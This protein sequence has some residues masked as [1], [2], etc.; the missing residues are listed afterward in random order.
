MYFWLKKKGNKGRAQGTQANRSPLLYLSIIL[1][2][3]R[4]KVNY[5]FLAQYL[6]AK[7]ARFYI[8][9][10]RKIALFN[11][12]GHN[13]TSKNAIISGRCLCIMTDSMTDWPAAPAHAQHSTH[14]DAL[15]TPQKSKREKEGQRYGD[16]TTPQH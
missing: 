9:K 7:I 13:G 14:G 16:T 12:I 6:A 8:S 11:Q 10:V 15:S 3:I 4:P 2:E 1:P 5:V